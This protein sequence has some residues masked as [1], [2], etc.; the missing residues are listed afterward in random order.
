MR[1]RGATEINPP[2][3]PPILFGPWHF[4][5]L[6]AEAE[7]DFFSCGVRAE[8]RLG[9]AGTLLAHAGITSVECFASPG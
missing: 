6:Y 2:N 1:Y 7:P 8:R 5:F 4:V 9:C 3:R